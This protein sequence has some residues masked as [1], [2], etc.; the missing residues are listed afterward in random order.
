MGI[1]AINSINPF[2][3]K[4]TYGVG[5][6]AGGQNPAAQSVSI[7]GQNSNKNNQNFSDLK[8]NQ[9]IFNTNL[10][11]K[12]VDGLNPFASVNSASKVSGVSP[13]NAKAN[14]MNG[15]A[16]ADNLQNV[17][18]GKLNGKINILNQIAIA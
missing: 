9:S 18:A 13:I 11:L 16:P 4:P 17:Y 14:Y 3:K 2:M 10:D 8:V 7:F 6:Y 15:L 12:K 5:M 1:G